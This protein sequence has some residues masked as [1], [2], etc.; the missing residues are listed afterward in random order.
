MWRIGI[1]FL[2]GHC[3]VHLLPALPDSVVFPWLL[4]CALVAVL[5]LRAVFIAT[6]LLGIG[7]AWGHAHV[8]LSEDLPAALEGRD[9]V[10]VGRIA[11]LLDT[12]DADPQFEFDVERAEHAQVPPRLRLAWYDTDLRPQPGEAWQFVVRLKRRNGFANPG[13]FDYEGYLFRAG[14]G[15]SGY[16]RTD[17][18]NLKLGDAT[19]AHA[20][21]RARGWLAQ[22]IA[23]AIGESQMLGIVQGLAVGDTQAMQPE[24]WRVFAATGTS[25][26]MAISGLHISMVAA[27]A[28]MMGRLIAHLPRA[29]RWRLTAMHGQ[30]IAGASAALIYSLL[31]GLSVPT[32]R[33]LVM[34]CVYFA[35]RWWRQ[36]MSIG[37]ALGLALVCVLLIDP[38][39]P[40]AVGAWL[41]FGAV[42]VIV[43]ATAG[44]LRRDNS[45]V[46]FMRVQWGVTI[47]LVP[48]L[49]IG[50][51]S[52]SLISPLANIA[53]VPL[54]TLV[55]VPL[56]LIGT[57]LAAVSLDA[58]SWV[59]SFAVKLLEW[60]WPGLQWLSE[61]PL[62]MWYLP[63][64]PLPVY[65][66]L[67]FGTLLFVL[68][69]AVPMRIVAFALCIPAATFL[70]S[71]PPV[72]GYDVAMLD[73]GQGLALVVRTHA[74]T[75]VY[76]A[77]PAFRTG[78]D[79]GELVVLPYLRH[80]GVRVIDRLVI[81]HGDLDHEGGMQ[82]LLRGMKTRSILVG[83][84]VEGMPARAARC[85]RGQRWVWDEVVFEIVHPSSGAGGSDNDTSCVLRVIGAGRTTLVTGDIEASGESALV[86]AAS[87]IA[88]IITIA[89][90]GSRTS[91]TPEF[92]AT[93]SAALALV[94]AGYRNRW[95]FPKS[96][97]IARWKEAGATVE[98]TIDS[99]ALE[100]SIRLNEPMSVRHF[101]RERRRYWTAR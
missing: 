71:R 23:L 57:A 88:D 27:L 89:H 24:Q 15:A 40:L 3:C 65:G 26:L 22:R 44:R 73:V 16:I 80:Q 5:A 98:S 52:L 54:F 56:V 74:H 86:A 25:H 76:D 38:F 58:G 34:L 97:V 32:Q 50:F 2:I 39:A 45:I 63:S 61:Q 36:S 96:D 53:A 12:R 30:A 70:P 35:V 91:S 93:T 79:T 18:R 21:L 67:A 75:L 82:S 19:L 85:E 49:V 1:A 99:G 66:L 11:S 72:G 81:S 7:W 17:S 62:A 60:C 92:V 55:V 41:S 43:L 101:R 10:V 100:V 29:Q 14:I 77:G 37:T 31:A 64:M 87:N 90:H 9:I 6:V 42:A 33:T 69:A 94:S 4:A 28:A 47:G 83:P 13:G 84:S 78:R 8:R 59:L 20:V 48:I 68:P 51:G 46:S 95:S